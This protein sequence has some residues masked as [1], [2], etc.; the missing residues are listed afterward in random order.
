VRCKRVVKGSFRGRTIEPQYG[1]PEYETVASFGSLLK[2]DDLSFVSLANQMCNAFGLDTISTGVTLAFAT[3]AA[4]KGLMSDFEG[5]WGDGES[6]IEPIEKI[7]AREGTGKV[8]G[9]GVMRIADRIGGGHEFAMH[10]KGMEIPMH[11]PRGKKALGISYA[12]SPRGASHLEGLHDTM[13]TKRT[14]PELGINE[15]MD[16]LAVDGKPFVAKQFEDARAFT[17]SIIMCVFTVTLTGKRYNLDLVRDMLNAANGYDIDA[18]EMLTIGERVY[19]IGR[20]FAIDQG[21]G[22][23]DDTL[24][25]RFME[26]YLPFGDRKE[27]ISENDLKR[28]VGEYYG[29]RG[30]DRNGRPTRERLKKLGIEY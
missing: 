1:G 26:E 10:V 14:S 5:R 20:L 18:E 6:F 17:N 7:A 19:N 27:R 8:L 2:V 28:M 30:W 21:L 16:R 3:E 22:P 29:F 25:P 15:P 11:E 9:D 23:G 4:E 12:T 13:I 24:P